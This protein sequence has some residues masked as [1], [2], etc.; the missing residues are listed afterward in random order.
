MKHASTPAS[1]FHDGIIFAC[2]GRTPHEGDIIEMRAWESAINLFWLLTGLA[3]CVYS[4]Q[5]GLMGDFGP[6]SGFFPLLAGLSLS[7][8][9]A[10]LLLAKSTRIP[11]ETVFWTDSISGGRVVR[12]VIVML[13][14][15]VAMP[16]LGFTISA[17]IATPLM[18]R[19][20]SG[21]SWI[22][23]ATVSVVSIVTIHLIFVTFL[24]TPMPRGPLGF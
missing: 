24:H 12:L 18:M 20:V 8:C 4:Q 19:V 22:L 14:L 15:I 2:P 10:A 11:D 23:G 7:V 17:L 13:G 16:W 9:G 6:D 21:A 1:K 3:V 5:L